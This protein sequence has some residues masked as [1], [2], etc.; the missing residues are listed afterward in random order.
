MLDEPPASG[1]QIVRFVHFLREVLGKV[2]APPPQE[3][4][5]LHRIIHGPESRE[6]PDFAQFHRLGYILLQRQSPTMGE[7]SQA[8]SV[9]LSTAT[10]M[11]NWWV[12]HG[13]AERL[14][15]P[16]DR[17]VVRLRL[18]PS[19]RRLLEALDA[20]INSVVSQVLACLTPEERDTLIML[21]AKVAANLDRPETE[22]KD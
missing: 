1:D 18:T 12:E 21:F 20:H 10:R 5:E 13:Y 19:G 22:E 17:R 3:V 15:D 9:P 11:A 8:L 7:L 16:E 4:V 6:R 2:A 14:S